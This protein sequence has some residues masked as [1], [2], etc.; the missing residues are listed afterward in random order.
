ME[1]SNAICEKK[2]GILST[3]GV[4]PQGYKGMEDGGL[5]QAHILYIALELS[6]V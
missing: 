1:S 5:L 4:S 6:I 2:T 3:L